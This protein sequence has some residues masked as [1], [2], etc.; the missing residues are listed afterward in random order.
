MR[1]GPMAGLLAVVLFSDRDVPIA[2]FPATFHDPLTDSAF[3]AQ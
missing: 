3:T 2:E 1:F